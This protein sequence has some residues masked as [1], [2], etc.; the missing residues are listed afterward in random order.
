[1]SQRLTIEDEHGREIEAQVDVDG[2]WI[3]ISHG[4]MAEWG[5][6][7]LSRQQTKELTAFLE[8]TKAGLT[9]E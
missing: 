6:I 2:C 9:C 4:E 7:Q 3:T 8:Q 5:G 1:M